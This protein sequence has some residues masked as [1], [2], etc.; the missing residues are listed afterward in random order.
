MSRE[1]AEAVAAAK[2]VTYP[3]HD[4]MIW[5]AALKAAMRTEHYDAVKQQCYTPKWK[6]EELMED[7]GE[8]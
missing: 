5:N 6:L 8:G 3:D 2:M 7:G 1:F 4:R